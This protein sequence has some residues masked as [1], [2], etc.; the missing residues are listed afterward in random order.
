MFKQE[1]T[2]TLSAALLPY[3]QTD[4]SSLQEVIDRDKKRHKYRK[5]I[6][7][8][9]DERHKALLSKIKDAPLEF[10]R[11]E[12]LLRK[13]NKDK[14]DTAARKE[15][16]AEQKALCQILID[17]LSSNNKTEFA[18]LTASTPANIVKEMLVKS[19]RNVQAVI[20][21]GMD[22]QQIFHQV[23]APRHWHTGI[24]HMDVLNQLFLHT[25]YNV[26]F[27]Q[28]S[29]ERR[30]VKIDN[31]VFIQMLLKRRVGGYL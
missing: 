25:F 17:W 24:D 14:K 2:K 11:L 5:D 28:V 26:S 16:E 4:V 8:M 18:Y 31:G 9:I 19:G 3:G 30:K 22:T 21:C 1:I 12:E 10:H 7:K 27:A 29:G 15:L 20:N 13:R 6:I 23:G